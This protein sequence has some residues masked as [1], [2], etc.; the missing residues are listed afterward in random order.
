MAVGI[1]ISLV[2]SVV[3]GLYSTKIAVKNAKREKIKAPKDSPSARFI[4]LIF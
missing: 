4:V 1:H 2:T 3:L